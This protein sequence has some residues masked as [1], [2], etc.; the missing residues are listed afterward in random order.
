MTGFLR[1][2]R[3][4]VLLLLDVSEQVVRIGG[5]DQL[6]VNHHVA[7]VGVQVVEDSRCVCDHQCRTAQAAG[8][9]Q[10]P[11]DG[12]AHGGDVFEVDPAFGFV[13]QANRGL[14]GER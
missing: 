2:G 13:K 11:V 6:A 9:L 4:G 12:R 8:A 7:D 3:D 5:I 10:Q 1:F 14:N